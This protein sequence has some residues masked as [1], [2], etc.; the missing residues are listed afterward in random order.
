MTPDTRP[1]GR[2]Q[3]LSPEWGV[4]AELITFRNAKFIKGEKITV[5]VKLNHL[6]SGIVQKSKNTKVHSRLNAQNRPVQGVSRR[7]ADAC[8]FILQSF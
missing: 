2:I 8:E 7:F 3:R 6:Y 5:T 1:F 4:W